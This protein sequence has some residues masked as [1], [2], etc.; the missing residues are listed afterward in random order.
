M[1]SGPTTTVTHPGGTLI[2]S[3]G[4]VVTTNSLAAAASWQCSA[5]AESLLLHD[6]LAAQEFSLANLSPLLTVLDGLL[7][8]NTPIASPPPPASEAEPAHWDLAATT[9]LHLRFLRNA[10]PTICATLAKIG[11]SAV[12]SQDAHSLALRR[13]EGGALVTRGEVYE[14]IKA[15][16]ARLEDP[17]VV[18]NKLK[19]AATQVM[20]SCSEV[21][22]KSCGYLDVEKI[23]SFEVVFATMFNE[24]WSTG[25]ET[26]WMAS[27]AEG[28]LVM[29]NYPEWNETHI[30]HRARSWRGIADGVSVGR[31]WRFEY[32]ECLRTPCHEVIHLVQGITKQLMTAQ[33]AEHDGAFSTYLLMLGVQHHRTVQPAECWAAEIA[34]PE[35]DV[36]V[37]ASGKSEDEL[38]FPGAADEALLESQD[39]TLRLLR[40]AKHSQTGEARW[41]CEKEQDYT[42]WRNSFGMC[43][44]ER[45][46]ENKTFITDDKLETENL[47]KNMLAMEAICPSGK[48]L[49]GSG[50]TVAVRGMLDTMFKDRTD[51]DLQGPDRHEKLVNISP[52]VRLAAMS[53]AER[54]ESVGRA[55]GAGQAAS[56]LDALGL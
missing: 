29:P 38:Y 55:V 54:L 36:P 46:G 4:G 16:E 37:C 48:L 18:L 53:V 7:A 10:L 17:A 5:P 33:I 50:V 26:A 39:Y 2:V 44:C 13:D 40:G 24:E 43:R 1:P 21:I 32:W 34:A 19:W 56:A 30:A 22:G 6:A 12:R 14:L 3:H 51:I 25:L 23:D 27:S 35:P 49:E 20:Q 45:W 41:T 15:I 52:S 8:H 31:I 11:V 47:C 28:K 9:A 42:A